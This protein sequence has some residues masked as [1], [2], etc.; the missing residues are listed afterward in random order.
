MSS[1]NKLLIG[2][3]W[4]NS[5]KVQCPAPILDSKKQIVGPFDQN[6]N[7]ILLGKADGHCLIQIKVNHFYFHF[8]SRM[9]S[10]RE[11]LLCQPSWM[12]EL[13]YLK[14][15]TITKINYVMSHKIRVFWRNSE[16]IRNKFVLSYIIIWIIFMHEAKWT[17]LPWNY[18]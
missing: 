13:P 5:Q 16:F 10:V 9:L 18:V 8:R 17:K 15:A 12:S 4:R 1:E 11:E 2:L 6:S 3:K 7:R 14:P